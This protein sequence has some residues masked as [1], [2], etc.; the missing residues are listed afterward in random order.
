MNAESPSSP[1]PGVV[2]AAAAKR[3]FLFAC[4]FSLPRVCCCLVPVS[5]CHFFF[6]FPI[7]MRRGE[8]AL[9][10]ALGVFGCLFPPLSPARS[11]GPGRVLVVKSKRAFFSPP[12]FLVARENLTIYSN[13]KSS[14]SS[15][16]FRSPSFNFGSLV[17][18]PLSFS[19][20]KRRYVRT[21]GRN[22]P[23]KRCQEGSHYYHYYS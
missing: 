7:V 10:V 6:F 11:V 13:V 4:R 2:F 8:C 16:P 17:L 18:S 9:F 14:S 1:R 5:P 3:G 21:S 20:R 22:G 12:P 15:S 19:R 23:R